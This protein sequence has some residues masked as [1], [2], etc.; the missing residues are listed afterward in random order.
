MEEKSFFSEEGKNKMGYFWGL[1]C[2][3]MFDVF[4][5]GGGGGAVGV[6]L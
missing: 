2:V 5:L 6:R 3:I 4:F 1:D